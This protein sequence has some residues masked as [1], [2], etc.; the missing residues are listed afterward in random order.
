MAAGS[1]PVSTP[2]GSTAAPTA[3]RDASRPGRPG[4]GLGLAGQPTDPLQP[5][6]RR[7]RGAAV[8]RAQ[9]VRLVGR[10]AAEVGGRRRPRLPG[11]QALATGPSAVSVVLRASPVTT[12]S[13]C[14]PMARAGCSRPRACSTARCRRTTSRRSPRSTTR[15]TG[16]R[17]TRREGCSPQ[18]QPVEPVGGPAG[19]RGLPVRVHDLPPHRAPTAGGMSRWLPYLAELQPE[20]FC[21]SLQSSLPSAASRT[22]AGPRSS[23][24]A[25][26]SRRECSSPSG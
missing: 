14:S 11:D 23:R 3:S 5:R 26:P 1:T 20:L 24:P 10:G 8:E 16:S 17:P 4:M 18:G 7:P 22:A 9:E 19:R 15:S 12:R 21:E 25:R 6:L 2:A 13:S